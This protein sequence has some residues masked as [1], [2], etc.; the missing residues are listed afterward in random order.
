M[1]TMIAS[2]LLTEPRSLALTFDDGPNEYWTPYVLGVLAQAEVSGTFFM[3]GECLRTARAAA[4]A[5][6]DAGGDLQLHCDR[7]V[8]HSELS[9][10]EIE[11]DT[12][13]ALEAFAELG[14]RPTLWRTPWG[15][16][17]AATERVAARHGLSLVGWTI[18][19]HD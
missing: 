18:D 5:V 15:V 12:L 16:C 1:P 2:Q 9:E 8:R 17:T 6:L 14:V 7:H 13:S 4:Q 10:A 3:I 19:T 11:A